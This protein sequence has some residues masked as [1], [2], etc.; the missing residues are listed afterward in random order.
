MAQPTRDQSEDRQQ[1]RYIVFGK[2]TPFGV[3]YGVKG[4]DGEDV[5]PAEFSAEVATA[6]AIE[7]DNVDLAARKAATLSLNAAADAAAVFIRDYERSYP[8]A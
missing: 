2:E 1:S 8:T 6:W 7:A 3:L 5:I 4:R